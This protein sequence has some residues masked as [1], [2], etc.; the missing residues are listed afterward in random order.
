[1][2]EVILCKYCK[3]SINKE[4]D[5]FVVVDRGTDRN[6]EV[7]AHVV[8]EQRRPTSLGINELVRLLRWRF[9]REPN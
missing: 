5:Q 8:C 4:A 1:M 3:Q 2:P 6:P 7:L 9:I